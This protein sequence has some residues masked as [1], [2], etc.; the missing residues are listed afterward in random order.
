[1]KKSRSTRFE[2][3]LAVA[4]GALSALLILLLW[5]NAGFFSWA[6]ARH[7]NLLSWYI[8]PLFL[9]PF[10]L[11]SYRRSPAGVLGTVFLL[12]TSMFWFPVPDSV[13]QQA[14][15]FLQMEMNYL[16]G[17]WGP[18]K[19]L[20]ALLVPVSMAALSAAFWKRSLWFGIA[21]L[22]FIAVAKV[23]W[24]AVFGGASGGSVVL[25]AVAGLVLCIVLVIVGYR[26]LERKDSR[27]VRRI[28]R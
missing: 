23:L 12:L 7:Q 6:F 16:T 10:C 20:I 3:P 13:D 11:F 18:T 2:K 14:A 5:T 21:V 24:S 26:Q 22:I 9:I 19:I 8:R 27:R 17:G 28:R 25:P 15:A 4:F 1:M